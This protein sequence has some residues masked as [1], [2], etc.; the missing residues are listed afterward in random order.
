[1][2][3]LEQFIQGKA[4]EAERCEDGI[5]INDHYIAAIDGVTTKSKQRW[6][7]KKTGK[8][9]TEIILSRL[10]TLAKEYDAE[11]CMSA[12][13]DAV[14]AWYHAQG[15][16]DEAHNNPIERCAASIVVYSACHRQIW[17]V[18][19]CQAL[20]DGAS[21][22][23]NKL[24]DM[25][26]G[27]AR[28]LFILSSLRQ[29]ERIEDFL[30]HDNGRDYIQPLIEGQNYFQNTTGDTGFEY[31]ALDGFFE[32]MSTI[33]IVDVPDSAREVVLATD[34]YLELLPTLKESERALKKTL[35]EDPLLIMRHKSLK[36]LQKG[37]NSFDDRAYIRF[38]P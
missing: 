20:I 2:R 28:A 23:N 3:V 9:A 19:D 32:D 29:G 13:N 10:A 31:E 12:L 21:F 16:Y 27:H 1:M 35:V 25:V 18:G 34:G 26:S 11:Q 7:G 15:M 4:P 33:K 14:V 38:S 5:F 22:T 36:G 24:V 8:I 30:E 37:N 6:D 17:F